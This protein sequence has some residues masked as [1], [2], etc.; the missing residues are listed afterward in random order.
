MCRYSHNMKFLM[1]IYYC[2]LGLSCMAMAPCPR[3]FW[4]ISSVAPPI[5]RSVGIPPTLLGPG[6]AKPYHTSEEPYHTSEAA[7]PYEIVGGIAQQDWFMELMHSNTI[8]MILKRRGAIGGDR[9]EGRSGED[10]LARP[11][12][13]FFGFECIST[14]ENG[15]NCSSSF[16]IGAVFQLKEAS[17]TSP[18]APAIV[19]AVRGTVNYH[20]WGLNLDMFLGR[21]RQRDSCRIVMLQAES[22][23]HNHGMKSN[24]WL[25]GHSLGADVATYVGEQM[26]MK[27]RFFT[28]FLFNPPY[29]LN[30]RPKD[31]FQQNLNDIRAVAGKLAGGVIAGQVGRVFADLV[32]LATN[33][34]DKEKQ[35]C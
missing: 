7:V 14:L 1:A 6:A 2:K 35:D 8:S 28:T 25:C 20:D 17:R 29:I 5:G 11:W 34:H 26:A 15:E 31:G 19:I 30:K 9:R 21:G 23:V 16:T 33:L 22:L 27:G 32:A 4:A 13:E 24:L 3:E 10:Q 18:S 12:W